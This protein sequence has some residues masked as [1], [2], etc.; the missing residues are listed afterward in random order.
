MFFAYLF[1]SLKLLKLWIWRWHNSHMPAIGLASFV[2]GSKFLLLGIYLM[3]AKKLALASDGKGARRNRVTVSRTALAV[4]IAVGFGVSGQVFAQATTGSVFGTAPVA[5]GETVRVV[6]AQT[7]LTREVAVGSDG[8]FGANQLPVGKYTVSLLQNGKVVAAHDN[9]QVSVSGGTAVPFAASEIGGGSVNA[10]N[11]STVTVSAN[12]LPPIDVSSTRQTQV[13][14]AEQLKSLPLAHTAEDIALLSPGVNMGG[15]SLGTGPTG[16]PLVSIGGNSVV[17][18]AYYLN[19]FNTTDPI[20]GAGGVALPYFAIAEQQ[21]I[22]S[23]YGPE[24]GR[25]TG[26]VISQIGQRGSNDFHAGVYVSWQPEF[27]QSNFDNIHY[28]NP[29]TP[30]GSVD[31]TGTPYLANQG[32]TNYPAGYGQIAVGRKQNDNWETVYDAYLSGPLIKDKLFFYITAEWQHDSSQGGIQT[33]ASGF[34]NGLTTPAGFY[35][36]QAVKSPKLYGKLDWNIN[37]SNVLEFTGVQT[38]QNQTSSNYYNYD[39]TDQKVGSLYGPGITTKNTFKVGILKYTSYIT[40]NLTLEAQYGVMTGQYY[41]NFAGEAGVAPVSFSGVPVPAG[42]TVPN[43]IDQQLPN[44]DHKTKTANLRVDLDWKI[45]SDHDLKFGIDNVQYRDDHDGFSTLGGGSYTYFN[46]FPPNNTGPNAV[47]YI[48]NPGSGNY[49]DEQFYGSDVSLAVRQKAQYV[50]DRWQVTPNLLLDLGVRNDQFKNLGIGGV[51]YVNEE[52]PQW[53]PRLGASWDVFGDSTFKVFGNAGRYYLAL[54]AGLATRNPA[55]GTIYGDVIYTYTGI[56]ANGVP[57]GLTPVPVALA[58]GVTKPGF[59]SS[60]GENGVPGNTKDYASTN[61]KAEYQDEY[62]LGFQKMLGETGLVLGMQG[63]YQKT[64][65]F[66]DDTDLNDPYGCASGLVNPGKTNYIPCAGA[67]GGVVTWNPNTGQGVLAGFLPTYPVK[68]TRKYYALDTYLEH[69]WDGKWFGK[70]DYVFSRSYGTDEGPTDTATGQI[71]NSQGQHFSG[72]TTA[73]WDYTDIEA[74]SN[75]VLANDHK[76]TFKAFGSYAITPEWM[77]SGTVIVQSGAPKVCLSGYGYTINGDQ[78]GGA[79]EHF[80]GGVPSGISTVPDPDNPG[81]TIGYGGVPSP[82]GATGFTP[83]THQINL[84]LT[85]TPDW[86]NKHLTLQAEV[87]NLLNEQ[88]ATLYTSAYANTELGNNRG[89]TVYNPTY[90]TPVSTES[91]RYVTFNA[92]Y[93]F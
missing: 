58:P 83:W 35:Q 22:T 50:E 43:L 60:D 82:A 84:S 63:T 12:K 74:N 65:N 64:G 4:A 55:F 44:P 46:G 3:N 28:N 37:D 11:L 36:S 24:Y 71:S 17:E 5:A 38:Q 77:V 59:Y 69:T 16:T 47:P 90:N 19:G 92:K 14:T 2:F 73:N 51:A 30:V 68:P 87:H 48:G 52:S 88:K 1:D 39:Y 49:V 21:T 61:L 57:T 54:P 9:V 29:N 56:D 45:T 79:Y 72:T 27:A 7:G 76:H 75:G 91:P 89:V 10:Q 78:Y 66:V 81:Q 26:G 42:V 18:N 85:Y 20:G 13:I 53:A 15:S 8:R 93:D 40:D 34:N 70:L 62:V 86:A 41:A 25:S 6:S 31:N 33:G 80:C 23:G 67:P 32:T